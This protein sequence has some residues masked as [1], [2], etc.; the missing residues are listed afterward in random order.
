MTYSEDWIIHENIARFRRKL[1][2]ATNELTRI[3][4]R[5]LLIEQESKLSVVRAI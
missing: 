3:S 2:D 4:L 5:A 1:A